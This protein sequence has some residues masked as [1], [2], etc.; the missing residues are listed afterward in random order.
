M[1]RLEK[2]SCT[3]NKGTI[4]EVSALR[5][6]SLQI[7]VGE[8]V[9]I[10][11]SNGS[12]KSTLLNLLA[13]STTPTTGKILLDTADVTLWPDFKRSKLI[14]RVFQNPLS[15]TAG[16]LSI[17]E[18]FRLAALRTGNRFLT[19][20]LTSKFR[21]K[22]KSEISRLHLGLEDTF[23]RKMG[24]LSGGQRQALTL[25]M[26][27][28]SPCK[29]LLLD[30]PTA[31]LDPRTS[32]MVMR[33]ADE[34]IREHQLTAVHITHQMKDATKYGDR[35]LMMKEGDVEKNI[36]GEE[37]KALQPASLYEWFY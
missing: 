16:E 2:I 8:Y 27:V 10:V 4:L 35:L 6:T 17:L 36:S 1:I 19:N 11:G 20:G 32:E 34:I 26:A 3:F 30:E 12:G 13:G 15:G 21:E 25:L 23:D 31:A 33:I 18:N 37:K 28:M 9:M 7:S 14:A 24:S 5:E 22:V 29:I